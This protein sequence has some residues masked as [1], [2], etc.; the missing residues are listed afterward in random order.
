MGKVSV[1]FNESDVEELTEIVI[2]K[3]KDA[4]LIFLKDKVLLQVHRK[5]K[6]KLDVQG[7]T[8]L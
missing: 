6:S 2:D 8:H 3:D 4:A 7:K 5:G 1:S